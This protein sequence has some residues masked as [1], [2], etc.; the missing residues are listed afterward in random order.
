MTSMGC[1]DAGD[2]DE[3]WDSSGSYLYCTGFVGTFVLSVDAK[4]SMWKKG[5]RWE[6][7]EEARGANPRNEFRG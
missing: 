1:V 7:S 3:A 6:G 5:G 4:F 2:V